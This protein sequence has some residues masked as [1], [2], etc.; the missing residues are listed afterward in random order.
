MVHYIA[1]ASV[2]WMFTRYDLPKSFRLPV[3]VLLGLCV[4]KAFLMEWV[5]VHVDLQEELCPVYV[6]K[7]KTNREGY[8]IEPLFKPL[9]MVDL[10]CYNQV[11]K[12][13]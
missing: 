11:F 13:S 1:M 5:Y 2:V 12:K 8:V 6:G 7:E 10:N 4:Y 3:T 9:R